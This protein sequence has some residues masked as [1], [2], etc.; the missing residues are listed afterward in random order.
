M[1]ARF[2]EMRTKR[3]PGNES[4][5]QVLSEPNQALLG[6]SNTAS[7]DKDETEREPGEMK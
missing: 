6:Q 3:E 2:G 5:N 1:L 4:S 7:M